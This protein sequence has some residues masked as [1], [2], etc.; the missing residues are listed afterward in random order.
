M[1]GFDVGGGGRVDPAWFD[2]V[3]RIDGD[4]DGGQRRHHSR[5]YVGG[6]RIR[7]AAAR[8][9][10]HRYR[11]PRCQVCTWASPPPTSTPLAN[12]MKPPT[13]RARSSAQAHAHQQQLPRPSV[14]PLIGP[15]RNKQP[16]S[17]T[18][19]HA[20]AHVPWCLQLGLD[21][22]RRP[23]SLGSPRARHALQMR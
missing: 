13:T 15:P 22:R 1:T 21:A 2:R 11:G 6:C 18:H 4:G 14:V 19:T 7:G 12:A 20:H 9:G 5:M 10:D 8:G 16:A 17:N 23:A 3:N